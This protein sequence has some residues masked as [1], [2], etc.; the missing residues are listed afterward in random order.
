LLVAPVTEPGVTEWDVYLPHA[1]WVDV[2]T[3]ETAEPGAHRVS[4]PI[5]RIPV[6]CRSER[7]RA[8]ASMF[9]ADA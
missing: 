3:G 1:E 7:W 8:L 4:T 6:F 9:G 5:D 2:W